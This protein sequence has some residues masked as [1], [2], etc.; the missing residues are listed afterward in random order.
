MTT[1]RGA[2]EVSRKF[3]IYGMIGLMIVV[4][5]FPYTMTN[6][7]SGD[8]SVLT[9]EKEKIG[10]CTLSIKIKEVRCLL[11]RY[12]KRFSFCLNGD[13]YE[14]FSTSTYNEVDTWNM[15]SQLYYHKEEDRFDL[16]VLIFAKDLSYAVIRTDE[17]L[18]FLNNGSSITYSQLPIS[19]PYKAAETQPGG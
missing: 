13:D 15:I 2:G 9:L 1:E 11:G 7:L 14:D 3:I 5:F 19:A 18:Y 17:N 12:S 4:L 6:V 10:E 16:C 8:G